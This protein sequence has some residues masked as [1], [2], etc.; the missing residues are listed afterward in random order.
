MNK[1]GQSVL[2]T[3]LELLPN[4]NIKKV[5]KDFINPN[6]AKSLYDIW[7]TGNSNNKKTYKKPHT[8]SLSDLQSMQKKGLIKIVGSN[9]EITEKGSNIIKIMILGDDRSSFDENDVI[10]DYN[11]ALSN[12][13]N[14]KVANSGQK[15]ASNWWSRFDK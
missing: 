6:V 3:F 2:D 5:N 9:I 13:K 12:T 10:I 14:I 4:I 7:R 8:S 15:V 1:R 11:E